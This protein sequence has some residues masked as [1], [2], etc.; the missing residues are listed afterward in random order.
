[1]SD[2]L[3][4]VTNGGQNGDLLVLL[5]L[6][7]P[8]VIYLPFSG[9]DIL[10]VSLVI[11]AL[12]GLMVFGV[13]KIRSSAFE[14][15][16]YSD[17]VERKF[18]RGS[19]KQRFSYDQLMEV[20]Y[21][22]SSRGSRSVFVFQDEQ[23]QFKLEVNPGVSGYDYLDFLRFIKDKNPEVRTFIEPKGSELYLQVRKEVFGDEI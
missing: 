1:M 12:I 5:F 2:P 13:R 20:H 16:F 18:K 3:Y 9:L 19:I 23:S 11:M 8:V 17:G 21:F 15:S 22:Q 10:C 14:L 6:L 4:K 7:V